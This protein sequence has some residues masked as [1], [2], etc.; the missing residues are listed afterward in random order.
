MTQWNEAVAVLAVR[1]EFFERRRKPGGGPHP[2][3]LSLMRVAGNVG[4]A[5][6]Y[7]HRIA[8][9]CGSVYGKVRFFVR[10]PVDSHSEVAAPDFSAGLPLKAQCQRRLLPALLHLRGYEHPVAIDY[11]R[12]GSPGCA[13]ARTRRRGRPFPAAF[14]IIST[15]PAVSMRR[16]HRLVLRTV[17]PIPKPQVS[18]Q[19]AGEKPHFGSTAV[20]EWQP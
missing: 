2:Y 12:T 10:S 7:V 14:P 9:D 20:V 16:R 15:E 4:V 17:L 19:S 3:R 8:C 11:L 5:E 18:H 1:I 6:G 13:H